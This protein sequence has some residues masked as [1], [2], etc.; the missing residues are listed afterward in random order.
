M[1][2][3]PD[4]A[5]R[6]GSVAVAR[7]HR[8]SELRTRPLEQTVNQT[9]RSPRPGVNAR[10]II[11]RNVDVDRHLCGVGGHIDLRLVDLTISAGGNEH[12]LNG[13]TPGEV[14]GLHGY[15]LAR[16]RAEGEDDVDRATAFGDHL[17]GGLNDI[18][19]W[20]HRWKDGH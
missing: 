14:A 4:A 16:G 8:A 18:E 6:L 9:R 5:R 2:E 3:R 1:F 10:A 13:Y 15:R 19:L 7:R 12:D 11:H 20:H 17:P